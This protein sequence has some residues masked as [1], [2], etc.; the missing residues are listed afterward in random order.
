MLALL[1]LALVGVAF[2][3]R[4]MLAGSRPLFRTGCR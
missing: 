2:E 4:E 3:L 1:C